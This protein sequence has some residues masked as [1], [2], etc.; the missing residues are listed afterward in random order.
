MVH[1]FKNTRFTLPRIERT[2]TL[3]VNTPYQP[4][5]LDDFMFQPHD[6]DIQG[7]T[8]VSLCR[9]IALVLDQKKAASY[10][11]DAAINEMLSRV[12]QAPLSDSYVGLS[13]DDLISVIKSRYI[14]A[15]CELLQWSEW[16]ENNLSSIEQAAIEKANA[17][18][19]SVDSVDA[20]SGAG[21]S[22][23]GD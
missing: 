21:D 1:V 20:S 3:S 6:V 18:G 8:S 12:R 11:L 2:K 16:L 5:P 17:D 19:D 7:N 22:G 14:Q 15:P 4:S 13:D 10:G 23:S 9:D